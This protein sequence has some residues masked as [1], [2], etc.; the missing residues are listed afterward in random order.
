MLFNFL[1]TL[2]QNIIFIYIFLFTEIKLLLLSELII[3]F[4]KRIEK[5]IYY[6]SYILLA[7][8]RKKMVKKISKSVTPRGGSD[9][10]IALRYAL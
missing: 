8:T 5:Y 2:I 3:Q 4:H 6:D 7:T 1:F 10:I 9:V